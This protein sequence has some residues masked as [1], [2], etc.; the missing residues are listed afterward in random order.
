MVAEQDAEQAAEHADELACSFRVWAMHALVLVCGSR[1]TLS[2]RLQ[3]VECGYFPRAVRTIYSSD[4]GRA[5]PSRWCGELWLVAVA[6]G[7]LAE[8]LLSVSS[9]ADS[10]R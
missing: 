4:G 1:L 9:I 7:A 5:S 6:G 2:L 3:S 10:R 8:L